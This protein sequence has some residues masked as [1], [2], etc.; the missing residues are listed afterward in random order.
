[1]TQPKGVSLWILSSETSRLSKARVSDAR[2]LWQTVRFDWH[3]DALEVGENPEKQTKLFNFKTGKLIPDISRVNDFSSLVF[4]LVC[5]CVQRQQSNNRATRMLK[6]TYLNNLLMWS[7]GLRWEL[8]E[9]LG[10]KLLCLRWMGYK[11]CERRS[12]GSLSKKC[13]AAFVFF[14]LL[15]ENRLPG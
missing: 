9:F 1:M 2:N 4:I 3:L 5:W 7:S 13:T 12:A 6:F 14:F 11:R 8:S 10:A 15:P